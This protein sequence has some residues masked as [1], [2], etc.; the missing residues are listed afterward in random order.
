MYDSLFEP[1]SY[2]NFFCFYYSEYS[3]IIHF[4]IKFIIV[5]EVF[6]YIKSEMA[7]KC[8][9]HRVSIMQRKMKTSKCIGASRLHGAPMQISGIT[10]S[11]RLL[12]VLRVAFS[13]WKHSAKEVLQINGDGASS[14]L[15]FIFQ[16]ISRKL[17]WETFVAACF[18]VFFASS[19]ILITH[20]N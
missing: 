5:T 20:K 17:N 4:T 14:F 6:I 2:N 1:S 3:N 7:L 8:K 10:I 11:A 15:W 13:K 16:L 12:F 18:I 19:P 9:I